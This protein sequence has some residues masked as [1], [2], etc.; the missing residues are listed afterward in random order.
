[1]PAIPGFLESLKQMEAIHR[2]KNDDYAD[3]SNP[4]S[5]FDIS[6]Y[7]LSHFRNPRDQ[8]FVSLIS[9]KLARLSTLLNSGKTPNNESIGDSLIDAANYCLL[10]K[11]DIENRV[12]L[13]EKESYTEQTPYERQCKSCGINFTGD[14]LKFMVQLK[15]RDTIVYYFCSE[16]HRNMFQI[17]Y[18]VAVNRVDY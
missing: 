7:M 13:D 16:S 1:M 18:E 9:T 8:S 6:S 14:P 12:E 4:L 11:C 2:S 15:G 17:G 3:S 5:N 10:W